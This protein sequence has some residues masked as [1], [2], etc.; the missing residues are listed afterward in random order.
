MSIWNNPDND[1]EIKIVL[2]RRGRWQWSARL[3]NGAYLCAG[4]IHGYATKDE[5]IKVVKT[6]FKDVKKVAIRA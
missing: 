1:V 2:N 6:V 4:S 5:A 3:V